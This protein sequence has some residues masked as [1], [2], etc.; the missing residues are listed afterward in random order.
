MIAYCL[1]VL[2]EEQMRNNIFDILNS[3][4]QTQPNEYTETLHP[5]SAL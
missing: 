1:A 3:G 2:D 5:G 4:V